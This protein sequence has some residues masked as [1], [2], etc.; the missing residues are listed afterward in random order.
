MRRI[1]G[2]LVIVGAVA[3][4]PPEP[5]PLTPAQ[6]QFADLDAACA[7]GEGVACHDAGMIG[8]EWEGRAPGAS[9]IADAFFLRGCDAR[10]AASCR[11]LAE[12]WAS[13]PKTAALY[14]QR[15]CELGERTSCIEPPPSASTAPTETPSQAAAAPQPPTPV[16]GSCFFVAGAGIAVTNHHVIDQAAQITL[17]DARGR[18]H[19]AKVLRDDATVDLAVLEA[20]T[21]HDIAALPLAPDADVALG[22]PVFTIGFPVPGLLGDDPKFSEGSLGGQTGLG[23]AWL[24]QVTVPV[25]PGNSGGPLVDHRGFV[26]GVIVAKLRADRLLVE[27]G[28]TPENVNFAIKSIELRRMLRGLAVPKAKAARTRQAAIT[29]TGASVCHVIAMPSAVQPPAPPTA[30][31]ETPAAPPRAPAETPSS[32][33]PRTA[34]QQRVAGDPYIY[35]D[36][37][38]VTE[39]QRVGIDQIRVT[40]DVCVAATG[41]VTSATIKESSGYPAYDTKLTRAIA[42]WR[43]SPRSSGDHS[44]PMCSVVVFAFRLSDHVAPPG[45]RAPGAVAPTTRASP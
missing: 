26:V 23:A 33:P 6:Q 39:M 25:Q 12:R 21:A 17:I 29:R 3:C 41:N 42:G 37:T 22:E 19:V 32:P 24:Y 43:Y 9:E 45:S 44:A 34:A 14:R 1:A 27:A 5:Q 30:P 16:S 35:P 13:Q 18:A 20:V 11:R 2:V 4:M 36:A 7:A 15:A 10:N 8:V 31:P 28:V 40:V 38:T